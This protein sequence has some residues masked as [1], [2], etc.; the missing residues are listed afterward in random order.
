MT[1]NGH[2]PSD[3]TILP[4]RFSPVPR[5]LLCNDP[6]RNEPPVLPCIKSFEPCKSGKHIAELH[7]GPGLTHVF[8]PASNE[9]PRGA[10]RRA[11]MCP[12]GICS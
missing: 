3:P 10:S 7:G 6:V 11:R 2:R 1:G 9:S 5:I 4:L 8:T 12:P